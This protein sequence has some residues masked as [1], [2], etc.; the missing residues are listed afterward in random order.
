M[1]TYTHVC[2]Y[3]HTYTHVCTYIHTYIHRAGATKILKKINSFSEVAY[4]FLVR[5]SDQVKP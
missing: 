2:T 1:H 3:M 5:K 4:L